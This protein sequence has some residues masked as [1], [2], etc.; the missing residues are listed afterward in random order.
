MHTYIVVGSSEKSLVNSG[1]KEKSEWM[2]K[3]NQIFHN[4]INMGNIRSNLNL[5]SNLNEKLHIC[6]KN[7]LHHNSSF[8]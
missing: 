8:Q 3:S 6:K 7:T 1:V 2:K 5:Q 4:I